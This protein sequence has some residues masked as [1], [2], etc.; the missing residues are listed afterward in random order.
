[1]DEVVT[2]TDFLINESH[3]DNLTIKLDTSLISKESKIN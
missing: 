2:N 1:M 3:S